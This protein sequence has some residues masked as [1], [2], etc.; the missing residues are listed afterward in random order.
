VDLVL[1][2]ILVVGSVIGAQVGSRLTTRL[3]GE[4]LR[5]LLA[6]VVVLTAIK[7][8]A[9]LVIRPDELFSAVVVGPG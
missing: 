5:G 4:H 8:G 7:I 2:A 9:D 6:A 3:R 1:A